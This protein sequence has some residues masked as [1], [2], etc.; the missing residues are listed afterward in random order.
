MVA[1]ASTSDEAVLL[2]NTF[3]EQTL[4]YIDQVNEQ[5]QADADADVEELQ[6][7][8]QALNDQIAGR[9]G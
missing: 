2:V 8:I 4:A 1:T 3:A 6:A 5:V 9:G 7:E